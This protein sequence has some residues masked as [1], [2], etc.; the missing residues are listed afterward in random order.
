MTNQTLS[1]GSTPRIVIEAVNGDFSV[2]G[3]DTE[4]LLVKA[5]DENIRIRQDNQ[6]AYF[7]CND[8]LTLR[9]PRG[10]SLEIQTVS[11]DMALRGVTG[12]V[13]LKEVQGD[14]SIR[15]AGSVVIERVNADFSL[16][17]ANGD[18]RVKKINADASVRDV[19]GNVT[20][21]L[22]A[23]DL[24]VRGIGGDLKA[25]VGA[26]AVVYLDP[27]A[28][29]NY[30]VNAGDDILVVLPPDADATLNLTGDEIEVDLPDVPEDDTT[31]RVVKLGNG[32]AKI[33]LSAGGELRISGQDTAGESADEF[34]NLAGAMFDWN[35]L[36]RDFGR[37]LSD[38]ISQ[39]VNAA[40]RR[41]ERKARE[42]EKKMRHIELRMTHHGPVPPVPPVPPRPPSFRRS[43]VGV[44]VS[45]ASEVRQ[46]V[47]DEE[48]MTILKMLQDKKITSEEADKL[49]KALEGGE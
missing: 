19:T 16:R 7:S 10:S 2:V 34:G 5:D 24:V 18:L 20:M 49:L 3:W 35:D 46:P 8:D 48:R 29:H 44:N 11:G 32:S 38:R 37:E 45:E 26:D 27:K 43:N 9:V 21:E 30:A 33:S 1:V 41:A 12:Q 15:D 28:D 22:V 23:A 31:S 4:E 25:T 17:G 42:A 40:T 13:E 36:G 6:T 39:R 47:S 14:L